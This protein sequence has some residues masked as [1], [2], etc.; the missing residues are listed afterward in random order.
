MLRVLAAPLAFVLAAVLVA[1]LLERMLR[2]FDLAAAAGAPFSAV[3]AMVGHLLPHYLGVALPAAFTVAMFLAL[4]RLSDDSELDIFLSSG[5]SLARVAL[6]YLV[7]A[8]AFS[9]LSIYLSGHLQPL[10]RYAYRAT[11]NEA[12]NGR[13]DTRVEE[14]RFGNAG[15]GFVFHAQRVDADKRGLEGVFVQR[16][17]AG[18]EEI[19]TAPRGRLLPEADGGVKLELGDGT[20]VRED[21]SGSVWFGRFSR[22]L[23]DADVRSKEASFRPRGGSVRELTLTELWAG[24]QDP[25]ATSLSPHRLAGEFHGRLARACVLPLL[26]LLAIPLGMAAKRGRRAAGAVFIALVLITLNHSLQFGESLAESGR[27]NAVVAVWLPVALFA[28]LSLL[29]FRSSLSWPGDNPVTRASTRLGETLQRLRR[30]ITR[31]A[32]R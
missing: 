8:A 29:F 11:L 23:I 13:W 24:M 22:A 10:N 1:Q 7:L 17:L 32:P 21:D 14:N 15:R 28:L 30:G 2:L 26:P 3:F 9:L 31:R 5:R 25:G 19:T 12:L 16:R 4:A 20:L 6:P 27:A 18:A